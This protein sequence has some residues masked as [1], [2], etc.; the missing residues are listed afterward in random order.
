MLATLLPP[1]VSNLTVYT[2]AAEPPPPPPPLLP[3]PLV[4][5]GLI[6]NGSLTIVYISLV[7]LTLTV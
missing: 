6:D 3:P 2:D 1:F 4:R 5:A 7:R